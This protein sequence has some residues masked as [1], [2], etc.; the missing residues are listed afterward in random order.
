MI[1]DIITIFPGFFNS[2]LEE[3]LLKKAKDKGIIDINLVD[4]RPF[5]EGRHHVTDDAPFGGGAGMVMM[6]E[7]IAKAVEH[8]LVGAVH[9]PPAPRT[10]KKACVILLSPQGKMLDQKLAAELATTYKRLVL[11]CG[12]YEGVDERV[13]QAIADMEISIGDYVLNGGEV[14]AAVLIEVVSRLIP[15]VVGNVESVEKD[16]FTDEPR[17]LKHPQFTRP[18]DWRGINAPEILLSGDHEKIRL[19]RRKQSLKRTLERRPELLESAENLSDEDR[20]LI[21]E[22]KSE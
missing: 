9:E 21:E 7:P 17:L 1:F 22:I 12:R 13:A 14:A 18:S 19:W 8:V 11:I 4:L 10:D 3:S 20:K 15:G 5:G 16:S 2:L 6:A